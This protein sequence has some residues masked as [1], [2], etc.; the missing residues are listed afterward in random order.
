VKNLKKLGD[1]MFTCKDCDKRH[2]HCHSECESYI[3]AKKELDERNE[4]IR[5][6]KEQQNTITSY[7]VDEVRKN[8]K[9]KHKK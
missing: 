1:V 6:T 5:K 8:T 2:L 3:Q 9:R 4:Q 7:I